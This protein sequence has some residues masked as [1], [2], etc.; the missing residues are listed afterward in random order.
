M[1]DALLH[2]P[3]L[4]A[5]LARLLALSLLAGSLCSSSAAHD[6]WLEPQ[7]GGL[8]LFNGHLHSAHEGEETMP[9]DPGFVREVACFDDQG[10]PVELAV[11]RGYPLRIQ[12]LPAAACV[13]ASSGFWSKT[14]YGT[15]NVP[16]DQASQVIRSWLS[17]EAVKFLSTWTPALARPLTEELEIV[18][19]TDPFNA[20]EGDKLE[21]LVT[22]EGRPVAGAIVTYDGK[23]RG[24]TGEEGTLRVRLRHGAFQSVSASLTRP[25]EGP[26]ADEVVRTA[27][28]NFL[29]AG[30]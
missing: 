23:P 3:A 18:P 9:Y 26:Q 13:S 8:T 27:Q 21:I 7:D 10:R 15:R 1:R 11:D 28:L 14:P 17:R 24:E 12:G 16:K 25:H 5:A 2:R 22:L 6:L 29:L 19:L 30:E 4:A 20:S